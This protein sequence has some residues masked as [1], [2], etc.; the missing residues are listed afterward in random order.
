[1]STNPT[2]PRV[3]VVDDS[4]I[5]TAVMDVDIIQAAAT[6]LMYD[7]AARSGDSGALESLSVQ[8][9]SELG[10]DAFGYVAAA[11]LKL[12]ATCVLEPI[13]QV[14]DEVAPTIPMR[15]QLADAAR[16]ANETLR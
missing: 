11:A 9:I 16:N 14:V 15:A 7:F 8:Y 2:Q 12:L 3:T 5:L 6:R 10:A 1:M 13:L 4:G